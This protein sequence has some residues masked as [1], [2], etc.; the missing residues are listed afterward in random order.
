METPHT[1]IL[2][3]KPPGKRCL[4]GKI[5]TNKSKNLYQKK[6]KEGEKKA[7]QCMMVNC[8]FLL[9]SGLENHT[10]E[11]ESICLGIKFVLTGVGMCIT[12][13]GAIMWEAIFG[14]VENMLFSICNSQSSVCVGFCT[15]C[16]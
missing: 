14:K 4:L 6:Q 12:N 7:T 2:V 10:R 5:N 3:T 11:Q 8:S 13:K 16:G 1:E 9:L 15:H